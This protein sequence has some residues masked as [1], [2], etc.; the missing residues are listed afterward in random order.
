MEWSGHGDRSDG[1]PTA[2]P[3]ADI[4][5][6]VCVARPHSCLQLHPAHSPWLPCWSNCLGSMMLGGMSLKD[7]GL[8]MS[9]HFT[10]GTLQPGEGEECAI[11]QVDSLSSALTEVNRAPERLSNLLKRHT[12]SA[13]LKGTNGVEIC[14]KPM[15]NLEMP[16][17]VLG[18]ESSCPLPSPP[19]STSPH[20]RIRAETS[21]FPLQ[22]VRDSWYH[23]E[24]AG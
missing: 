5:C 4:F 18:D 6:L 1:A 15:L 2:L 10:D 12:R 13:L 19:F 7:Q 23:G 21:L 24:L 9:P 11:Y 17:S 16:Y 20:S 22:A 3:D 8:A 14:S